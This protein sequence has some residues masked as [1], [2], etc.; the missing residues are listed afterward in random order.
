[1]KEG[2]GKLEA[3]AAKRAGAVG[4][5]Y[6]DKLGKTDLATLTLDEYTDFIKT[7]IVGFASHMRALVGDNRTPPF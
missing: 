7:V 5:A 2:L 6:L 1:M 3:D 4:G